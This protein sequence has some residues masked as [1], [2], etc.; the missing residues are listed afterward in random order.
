M[1]YVFPISE[2]IFCQI[3]YSIINST[4]STSFLILRG[5]LITLMNLLGNEDKYYVLIAVIN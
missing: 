2:N 5:E 1:K 3:K 4:V